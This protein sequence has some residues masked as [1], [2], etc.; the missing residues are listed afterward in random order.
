[1]TTKIKNKKQKRNIITEV[2]KRDYQANKEVIK[3]KVKIRYQYLSEEQKKLKRQYIRDRYKQL[4]EA[5][6]KIK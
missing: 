6:N 4:A 2:V 1:M 3:K 5:V